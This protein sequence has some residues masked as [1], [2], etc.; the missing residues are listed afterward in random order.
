M[1]MRRIFLV[2]GVIFLCLSGNAWAQKTKYQSIFIYNFIKYIKWPEAYNSGN[3]VIGVLGGSEIVSSL[4]QMASAKKEANGMKLEIRTYQNSTDIDK[5]HIL[6]V[7]DNHC[8]KL[9][10]I[11][12]S[13]SDEPILIVT[14]KPGMA[15]KG[16]AINF[17][18]KDGKIKFELNQQK[19]TSKG[20]KVSSSL[21]SLAILI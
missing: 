18:E 12:S 3:F 2:L 4:E 7:S 5:C 13:I 15:Q 19:T 8:N 11:S 6:F 21:T 9:D 14:D 10:E 16:A 1:N 17:V 20:L